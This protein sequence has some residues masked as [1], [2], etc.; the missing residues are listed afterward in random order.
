MGNEKNKGQKNGSGTS[1]R[2]FDRDA[3]DPIENSFSWD[4]VDPKRLGELIGMVTVRGGAI[5]FGYSRDG[6]AGS[7]GVYYG[8]ARDT[9][10][11]RPTDNPEDT[12]SFIERFFESKG[13]TGGRAP[14]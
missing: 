14:G 9:V 5:R 8:E 10:Y 11:I 7:I 13:I 3:R 6:N 2:L 12:F 4:S 1:T